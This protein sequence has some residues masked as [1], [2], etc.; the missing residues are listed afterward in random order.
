MTYAKKAERLLC[1]QAFCN[2]LVFFAPVALLVRTRCGLTTRQVFALQALLSLAIFC[3][4]IPCGALTDRIGYK[5]TLVLSQTLLCAVRLLFLLGGNFA[6]FAVAAVLESLSACCASG[7][8][9]AYLYRA[10]GPDDYASVDSALGAWGTAG[11]ILSTVLFLPLNRVCG[12]EGLIGWTFVSHCAGLIVTVLLPGEA[13]IPPRHCSVPPEAAPESSALL[14]IQ[15]PVLFPLLKALCSK[16]VLRLFCLSGMLSLGTFIVNFF[17]IAKLD[18]AG[19]AGQWMGAIILA[20]SAVQLLAP[21]VQ[22]RLSR[23]G[24]APVLAAEFGAVALLLALLARSR[25]FAVLAPMCLL[26]FLLSLPG[27][28]LSA[29]KNRLVDRLALD[30]RRATVL[31]VLSQGSNLVDVLFLCA[32][33]ALPDGRASLLFACTAVLFAALGALCAGAALAE[34]RGFRYAFWLREDPP[35]DGEYSG[36]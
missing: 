19:L 33:T 22:R 34:G 14:S 9:E 5:K 35:S 8:S 32:A 6:L 7:T 26:P 31:S 1:A 13:A 10:C 11:F 27:P 21:L 4:E 15:R 28:L 3:F 24:H 25:G 17:F 30:V 23:F 36:C 16:E 29:E 18:E 12:I 2:S 20:Y